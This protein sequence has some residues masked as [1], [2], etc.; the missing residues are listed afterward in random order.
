MTN[1]HRKFINVLEKYM[2]NGLHNPIASSAIIIA[3][4]LGQV[5]NPSS[6]LK[7]MLSQNTLLPLVEEAINGTIDGEPISYTQDTTTTT[8]AT[9]FEDL[10]MDLVS[11]SIN[12]IFIFRFVKKSTPDCPHRSRSTCQELCFFVTQ[13]MAATYFIST[14]F[15]H[16]HKLLQ[17]FTSL[18][19]VLPF[20]I[21]LISITSNKSIYKSL[22]ECNN[23]ILPFFITNSFLF[24]NTT[25][26]STTT[27]PDTSFDFVGWI[28]LIA[29]YSQKFYLIYKYVI[30]ELITI[31]EEEDPK[32]EAKVEKTSDLEKGRPNERTNNHST[33]LEF[34]N[35]LLIAACCVVMVVDLVLICLLV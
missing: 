28:Y 20:L 10:L 4:V 30:Y 29:A 14:Y 13:L 11:N 35:R 32:D 5:I 6:P 24:I 25:F 33:Y 3:F 26:T 22:R 15:S 27:S 2:C 34:K 17:I 19:L 31:Y 9:T 16:F 1:T 12:L 7:A 21:L 18:Q 23:N 8:A